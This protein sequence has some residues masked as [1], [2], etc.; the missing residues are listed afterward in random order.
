MDTRRCE[1]GTSLG[2]L[3]LRLGIGGLL[4]T[5]GWGKVQMLQQGQT[6]GFGLLGMSPTM[7]LSLSMFAEFVCA[8]LVMAGLAT[9]LAAIP[10]VIN[11]AV[12]I[13]TAHA[14][15]PWSS[16]TAYELFSKGLAKSAASK[17]P[18]LMYLIPFLAL[19]FTG[20]GAF[21]LDALFLGRRK[22]KAAEGS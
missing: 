7:G 9:R 3:I 15:D 8:I 20:A 4:V 12:A 21:S 16:Q 2:L 1:M 14:K 6:T 11:M 5:H 17:E 10:V 13:S 19:V 22:K 18:A